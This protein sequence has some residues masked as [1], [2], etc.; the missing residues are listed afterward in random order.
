MGTV[1]QELGHDQI[2]LFFIHKVLRP[3][4]KNKDERERTEFFIVRPATGPKKDIHFWNPKHEE[5]TSAY[6]LSKHNRE[7]FVPE[8][9]IRQT[10][11]K[12]II[13]A[14]NRRSGYSTSNW[15][16]ELSRKFGDIKGFV[17]DLE[18]R[19][20]GE[21]K[22]DFPDILGVSLN[23]LTLGAEVKYE[24]FSKKAFS[25]VENHYNACLGLKI[26]YYL[27]IPKRPFYTRFNKA[28]V[29]R[30]LK[31]KPELSLYTFAFTMGGSI[32]NLGSIK[33][34]QLRGE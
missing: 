14:A 25:Q 5:Y 1:L 31:E 7:D 30:V 2:I 11:P 32:P 26:P 17:E 22:E 23:G 33:F 27:V 9:V 13:Q 29:Q 3:K 15:Y 4:E 28:F 20:R 24:G 34:E 6:N 19:I 12:E 8:W 16:Q 21:F 10:L 18:S